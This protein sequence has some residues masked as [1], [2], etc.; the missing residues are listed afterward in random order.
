MEETWRTKKRDS[1][2]MS[3]VTAGLH[4]ASIAAGAVHSE[5]GVIDANTTQKRDHSIF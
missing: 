5:R 4:W 2:P 1:K 3:R